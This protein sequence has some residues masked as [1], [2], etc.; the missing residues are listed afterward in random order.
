MRTKVVLNINTTV[1]GIIQNLIW[2]KLDIFTWNPVI[3]NYFS[4]PLKGLREYYI[5]T[6]NKNY[7]YNLN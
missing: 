3:Q 1:C 7:T 4:Y 2:S 6:Q 5:N